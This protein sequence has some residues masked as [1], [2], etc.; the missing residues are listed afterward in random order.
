ALLDFAYV[1]K[2]DDFLQNLADMAMPEK[3]NYSRSEDTRPYPI[4]FSYLNHTFMRLKEQNKVVNKDGFHCFNTG[5]VTDHQQEIF[6]I[7]KETDKRVSF[8]KFCNESDNSMS[9][10]SPL[11]EKATYFTNPADLIFDDRFDFRINI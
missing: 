7:F 5:L 3:W 2:V 11:P 8:Y 1:G 6:V 10:Y 4:L 9:Y